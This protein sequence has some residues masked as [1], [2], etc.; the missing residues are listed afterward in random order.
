MVGDTQG[1][2]ERRLCRSRSLLWSV[3]LFIMVQPDFRRSATTVLSFRH[4][5]LSILP[6]TRDGYNLSSENLSSLLR[7]QT[8]P[9]Q[10]EKFKVVVDKGVVRSCGGIHI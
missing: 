6:F 5:L 2:N 4:R 3:Q 1:D 7:K 10:G 9:A 8:K